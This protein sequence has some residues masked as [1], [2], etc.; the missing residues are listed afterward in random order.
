[1]LVIITLAIELCRNMSQKYYILR[2]TSLTSE[3][4]KNVQTLISLNVSKRPVY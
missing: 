2:L 1:M 3:L 4:V